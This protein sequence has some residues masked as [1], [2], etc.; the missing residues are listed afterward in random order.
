MECNVPGFTTF[1]TK[2][3]S[4]KK[5]S[6]SIQALTCRLVS[7]K[8]SLV[9]GQC[10]YCKGCSACFFFLP[11]KRKEKEKRKQNAYSTGVTI[12]GIPGACLPDKEKIKTVHVNVQILFHQVAISC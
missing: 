10:E 12:K 2:K 7:H 6:Q 8:V 9:T 11:A 3:K 1:F 5:P 4:F